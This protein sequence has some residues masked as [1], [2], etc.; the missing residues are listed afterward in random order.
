MAISGSLAAQGRLRLRDFAVVNAQ[1]K[2]NLTRLRGGPF[3]TCG[4][5]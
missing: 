5:I 4:Y 3:V 2:F 1:L